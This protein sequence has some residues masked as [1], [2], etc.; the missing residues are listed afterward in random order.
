MQTSHWQLA[1]K[2]LMDPGGSL[3]SG[4]MGLRGKS[5]KIEASKKNRGEKRIKKETARNIEENPARKKCKSRKIQEHRGKPRNIEEKMQIEEN[6]EQKSK[7]IGSRKVEA[8]RKIRGKNR[9][10]EKKQPKNQKKTKK[11]QKKPKK[12]QKKSVEVGCQ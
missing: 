3:D 9:N 4:G 2:T 1:E 12:N 11:N 5:R 10:R 6:R 8:S 7:K